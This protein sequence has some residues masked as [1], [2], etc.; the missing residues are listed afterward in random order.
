M[1]DGARRLGP[2]GAHARR[3]AAGL[4]VVAGTLAGSASTASAGEVRARHVEASARLGDCMQPTEGVTCQFV[5]VSARPHF[6]QLELTA[7]ELIDGRE[8]YSSDIICN[9]ERARVVVD[10]R[11]GLVAY[12][13]SV[14]ADDCEFLMGETP[15]DIDIDIVWTASAPLEVGTNPCTVSAS[16][17]G[18]EPLTTIFCDVL[19]ASN[20]RGRPAR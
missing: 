8:V 20:S 3:L 10:T 5:S 12:R 15:G 9:V 14:V 11:K 16:I 18:T 13:A 4:A 6:V 7:V 17:D 2:R 19:V 1:R